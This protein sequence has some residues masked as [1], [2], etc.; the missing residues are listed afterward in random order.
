MSGYVAVT[1]TFHFAWSKLLGPK[2]NKFL[3]VAG[4][5]YVYVFPLL[6]LWAWKQFF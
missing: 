2:P 5:V 4:E 3:F 1:T 6:V